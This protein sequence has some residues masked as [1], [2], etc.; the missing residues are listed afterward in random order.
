MKLKLISLM[1]AVIIAAIM[2]NIQLVDAE[3]EQFG[4]A[5]N[6]AFA[7]KLWQAMEDLN[8]TGNSLKPDKPY[9]GI[10][11]HG[12]VLETLIDK[13]IVDDREGEVLLKRNYGGA[14]VS[15]ASVGSN[16]EKF[17]NDLTVMFKREKGYDDDNQ[18]WFWAKFNS[19]GS[20]DM[21]P[22]GKKLAGRLAK[23]KA[24]GCIACHKGAPGGDYLFVK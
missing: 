10:H 4:D 24:K 13:I 18:D 21:N 11:P 5:D 14:G 20:L 19:D 8:L 22:R 17:L 9:T 16:R 6:V 15:I 23:G 12:T 1:G 3:S 2:G 7:K